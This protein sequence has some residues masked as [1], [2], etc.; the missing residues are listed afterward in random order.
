MAD[1]QHVVRAISWK[2]AFGFTYLFRTFKIA[3][4]PS[5]IILALVAIGL[6]VL[7]GRFVMD[8]L[9]TLSDSNRVA[10]GET[11]GF[12]QAPSR[13][14]FRFVKNNWLKNA[15]PGELQ[16]LLSS[17]GVTDA[18]KLVKSD[19]DE[20][21]KL[22]HEKIR[23]KLADDLKTAGDQRKKDVDAAAA[24]QDKKE[25]ADALENA[26][27]SYL[28]ARHSAVMTASQRQA[29]LDAAKGQGPFA[30]FLQ[31]E[32]ACMENAVTA[33][34]RGEFLG[35]ADQI[36]RARG[37]PAIS[38][39]Q[40]PARAQAEGEAAAN[41]PPALGGQPVG[42]LGWLLMMVVGLWWLIMTYPLYAAIYLLLALAIWAVLG[43]AICRIAALQSAR[44]EK[45]SIPAAIRFALSRGV[46]FLT[47]PLL[48]LALAGL[49]GLVMVLGGLLGMIPYAG[50]WIVAILFLL[51]L[52]LGAMIAFMLIGLGGGAPLMWPTIAV[53]GSDSFDAISR[54]F[55]YVYARP[56]RYGLYWL[57]T[58]VY[59]TFCYL[60][61][62]L[63]AY[64]AL[65]ATHWFVSWPMSWGWNSR[66]FFAHGAGKLDVM[67]AQPTFDA[68]HPPM[69]TF[70]MDGSEY[71]AAMVLSFW[72]YLV[73]GVVLAFLAS[74]LLSAATNI[75]FL[76]RQRVDSTDLD[77]VYVEEAEAPAPAPTPAP[78][79]AA[80]AESPSNVTPTPP[81]TPTAPAAP[82][83]PA[84]PAASTTPETPTEPTTP[85]PATGDKL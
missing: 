82:E 26:E 22:A 45:I 53:E 31:W 21:I 29:R 30:A 14:D 6:T 68:F 28:T 47:A 19:I 49:L 63:F 62:R 79:P 60:F 55:N 35:G 50:E 16:G 40:T 39:E 17:L 2:E 72:V 10:P 83:P 12:W 27:E 69:Q 44:D 42:V 23:A 46:S 9:W 80:P 71:G 3:T 24:K 75:Y 4:H 18:D 56:F 11:W 64:L 77:D 34:R 85:G 81:V 37:N 43:G 8:P 73:A 41:V 33:V 57:V 67:W 51:P 20:A 58:L 38:A 59:G 78:A 36:A 13:G 15:R 25:K 48:P 54:S 32:A 74:F 52:I 1:E 5:K 70:A 7:L 84:A 66:D 65:A 61:V 76:M